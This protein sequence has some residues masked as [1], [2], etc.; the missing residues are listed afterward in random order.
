MELFK[1]CKNIPRS[2]SSYWVGLASAA[3]V[4]SFLLGGFFETN[5]YD[6]EVVMVLVFIMGLP[7]VSSATS[8]TD[9]M[10]SSPAS[11]I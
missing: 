5:F 8:Q 2:S 11:K 4:I 9:S 6:S 10:R 1:L 3:V 7:F